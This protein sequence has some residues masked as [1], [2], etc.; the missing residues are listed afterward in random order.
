MTITVVILQPMRWIISMRKILM[1][2]PI[3][4]RNL[5][6]R[7]NRRCG[8][9]SLLG[10]RKNHMISNCNFLK[11]AHGSIKSIR[12]I[13]IL[14]LFFPNPFNNAFPTHLFKL[15][16]WYHIRNPNRNWN[17]KHTWHYRKMQPEEKCRTERI[18]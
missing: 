14:L 16:L 9:I 17:H 15:I 11:K 3:V 8:E 10:L 13:Y 2:S 4:H 7:G 18:Y 5:N 1:S 6:I 12:L